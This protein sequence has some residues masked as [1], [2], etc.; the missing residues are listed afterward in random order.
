MVYTEILNKYWMS[1]CAESEQIGAAVTSCSW[2]NWMNESSADRHVSSF[3]LSIS[4]REELW[5]CKNDENLGFTEVVFTKIANNIVL[6]KKRANAKNYFTE[7]IIYIKNNKT[8]ILNNNT[9]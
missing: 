8:W 5:M 9:I 7:K 4:F 6:L 2:T 3:S 1:L